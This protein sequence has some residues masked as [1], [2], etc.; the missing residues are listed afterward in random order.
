MDVEETHGTEA[1]VSG[2]EAMKT[3]VDATVQLV[4]A[5]IVVATRTVAVPIPRGNLSDDALEA[6]AR[7]AAIKVMPGVSVSDPALLRK[8]IEVA[9]RDPA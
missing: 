1:A 3:H 9:A 8:A 2:R 6:F 7:Q 5:N 4:I